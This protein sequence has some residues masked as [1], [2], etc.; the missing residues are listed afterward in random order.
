M[1][2]RSQL[3]KLMLAVEQS[4]AAVVITDAQGT[5]EFVNPK[6]TEVTGFL[7]AEAVGKNPRILKSGKHDEEFYRELW[8]TISAGGVWRGEF[9]N[10]RKDGTLYWESASVS[11]VRNERHEITNFVAVKEDITAKVR[12]QEQ[13]HLQS[14]AL[15]AAANSIFITDKQGRILWAN[16]AFC[17]LT[18]FK[19][20]ELVNQTPR[21][22]KSGQHDVGFYRQLW[23]TILAGQV[24]SGEVV[25]RRKNGELY[26]VHMNRDRKSVV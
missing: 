22:L 3:N 6:F 26:T 16:A 9:C 12:D 5:I 23:Q 15:S 10:K 1:L 17:R 13:L 20:D 24:W 4:P 19:M 7:A 14:S 2:F 18:G 8:Q 11:A 21:I 25:E